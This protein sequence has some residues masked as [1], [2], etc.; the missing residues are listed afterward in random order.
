MPDAGYLTIGKV[1]KRMQERY[2]AHMA[3]DVEIETVTDVPKI[4]YDTVAEKNT[5]KK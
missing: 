2:I 3:L 1:V 5:D 4:L